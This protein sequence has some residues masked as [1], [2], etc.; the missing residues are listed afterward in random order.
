MDLTEETFRALARSSPWR[1]RSVHLVREVG[2]PVGEGGVE[3][4]VRRPH[5]MRVLADGEVH[6]VRKRP[7]QFARYGGARPDELTMAADV[8]P[9]RDTD[10]LVLVRPDSAVVGFDDPM[11]QS[12]DWVAMLDPVELADGDP[13]R[14]LVSGEEVEPR[15]AEVEPYPQL[16]WPT[17]PPAAGTILSDL[18]SHDRHGRETWWARVVPTQAYEPRCS[19]CPLLPSEVAAR[20]EYGSEDTPFVPTLEYPEAH[21]VAL[22]V[23]TGICVQIRAAGGPAPGLVHDLRILAVDEDYGDEFFAPHGP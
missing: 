19:C 1:W 16:D 13:W 14:D 10:G 2:G 4:W 11:W 17:S 15:E 22:D 20:L 6:V 5:L 8:T 23:E 7:T 9:V 12:Y 3:A 21:E 18:R